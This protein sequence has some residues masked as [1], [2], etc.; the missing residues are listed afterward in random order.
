[1][2]IGI[3]ILSVVLLAV[4]AFSCSHNEKVAKSSRRVKIERSIASSPNVSDYDLIDTNYNLPEHIIQFQELMEETFVWR[5]RAWKL[6]D[7]IEKENGDVK[8]NLAQLQ[9]VGIGSYKKL[10]DAYYDIIDEYRWIVNKDVELQIITEGPTVYEESEEQDGEGQYWNKKI[11]RDKEIV[12]KINR[13]DLAG[14][15]YIKNIKMSLAAALTLYD[16]YIF[17]IQKYQQLKRL[18]KVPNF[19]NQ[20]YPHYLREISD[21]FNDL[22]NFDKVARAIEFF[23]TQ[24]DWEVAK[25]VVLDRDNHYFNALIE[26]NYFYGQ[27]RDAGYFILLFTQFESLGEVVRDRLLKLRDGPGV[28]YLRVLDNFLDNNSRTQGKLQSLSPQETAYITNRLMPLDILVTRG[29]HRLIDDVIPG[30]WGDVFLWTGSEKELKAQGLWDKITLAQQIEISKGATLL[31]ATR[32]GVVQM[33]PQV[34][35]LWRADDL[36]VI[37]PQNMGSS[38]VKKFLSNAFLLLGREYDFNF[39]PE[40]ALKIASAELIYATFN[41]EKY[42]W[43]TGKRDGLLVGHRVVSADVVIAKTLDNSGHFAPTL[44]YWAGQKLSEEKDRLE[45][46]VRN[47]QDG[48]YGQIDFTK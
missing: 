3:F 22:T 23:K 17:I 34:A 18:G 20:A 19:D 21:E 27:N 44:L 2:K 5:Q 40:S 32:G 12:L 38:S 35:Q 46:N 13:H 48:N 1:M 26:K 37:R 25:K 10:R 31:T 33:T 30:N 29:G 8:T 36:L 14:Q 43:P 7:Q 39:N 45:I 28:D 9:Q 11:D 16:N 6:F 15:N 41:D 42:R 4:V 24:S 47:I